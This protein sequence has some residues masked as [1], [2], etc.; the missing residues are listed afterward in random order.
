MRSRRIYALLFL[1]KVNWCEDL[2]TSA[3]PTLKMTRYWWMVRSVGI[4]T[5]M[6]L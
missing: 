3:S 5:Y 1:H 4:R 6:R 2:S